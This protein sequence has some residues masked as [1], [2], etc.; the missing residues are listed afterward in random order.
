MDTRPEAAV[1]DD[2]WAAVAPLV[3]RAAGEPGTAGRPRLPDRAALGGIL[4]VLRYD[5]SWMALPPALGC[6]AG[7]TCW[8]RLCEWQ[9]AGAWEGIAR[10]LRRRLPWAGEVDWDRAWAEGVGTQHQG[11]GTVGRRRRAGR[12]LGAQA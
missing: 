12:R 7:V 5:L 8:R 2:A 11:T 1:P 10:E 9:R 6:G 3:S 4:H